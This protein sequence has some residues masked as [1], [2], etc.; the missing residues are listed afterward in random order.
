VT[1]E[2]IYI[3]DEIHDFLLWRTVVMCYK[4]TEQFFEDQLVAK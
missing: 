2:Q 1:V 3:P 4:A